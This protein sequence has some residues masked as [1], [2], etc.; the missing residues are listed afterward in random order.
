[1]EKWSYRST[2]QERRRWRRCGTDCYPATIIYSSSGNLRQIS[3]IHDEVETAGLI[4]PSMCQRAGTTES[5]THGNQGNCAGYLSPTRG[6]CGQTLSMAATCGL[7]AH[8]TSRP[9]RVRLVLQKMR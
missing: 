5:T 9:G 4:Q 3:A 8:H 6:T 1:M 7:R 2:A